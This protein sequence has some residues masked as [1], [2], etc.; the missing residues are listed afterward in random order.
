MP[1]PPA[2]SRWSG[3]ILGIWFVLGVSFWQTGSRFRTGISEQ[4]R[5][6]LILN[7]DST[8]G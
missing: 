1:L 6:Q 5:R 4:E 3:L 8:D 7:V 2:G